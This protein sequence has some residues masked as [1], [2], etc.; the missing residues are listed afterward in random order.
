MVLREES[1]NT[2]TEYRL[3]PRHRQWGRDANPSPAL[4]NARHPDQ[5]M[6]K[7]CVLD[8][9]IPWPPATRLGA[10][11]YP[12]TA[13]VPEL[14]AVSGLSGRGPIAEGP[15]I[16]LLGPPRAPK[17]PPHL[18]P[19]VRSTPIPSD[20]TK[21][22]QDDCVSEACAAWGSASLIITRQCRAG[23]VGNGHRQRTAR[24]V[25]S[26]LGR[27]Q[28]SQPI[29]A[30]GGAHLGCTSLCPCTSFPLVRL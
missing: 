6:C 10:R 24:P 19:L 2:A 28:P 11:R 22:A 13:P 1:K 23:P 27:H 20:K 17:H 14:S 4:S 5:S 29:A 7:P 16:A 21:V 25:L 3:P 18:Q 26:H 15:L 8:A 12:R 9:A 30:I